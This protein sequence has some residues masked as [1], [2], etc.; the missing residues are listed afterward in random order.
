MDRI[1]TR[2]EEVIELGVASVETKGGGLF[3]S[4]SISTQ[5]PLSGISDD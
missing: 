1:E 4:D 2:D 3:V 5:Q